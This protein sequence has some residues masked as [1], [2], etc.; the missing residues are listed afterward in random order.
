MGGLGSI[1]GSIIATVI[2]RLLP[3]YLRGLQ[4]KR[5]IIYAVV[6]IVIMIFNWNPK[7][8]ELRKKL[9]LKGFINNKF[10]KKKEEISSAPARQSHFPS[11][12]KEEISSAPAKQSHF[13]SENKED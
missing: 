11:E 13:P 10:T 5:M 6:L 8:I 4:D 12:N 1:R 3:E 7:C 9:S 2:I